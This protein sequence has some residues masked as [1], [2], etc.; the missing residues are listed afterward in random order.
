MLTLAVDTTAEFGSISLGNSEVL[1]HEPKGFSGVLFEQIE[2][3]LEREGA[4]LGDIELLAGA[5]GPGSF[6]GVRI[7]LAAIKGLAEVLGKPAIAISNLEALAQF[8]TADLRATILDAKRGEIY[9]ALFDGRGGRVMEETVIA[10]PK[11]L[12]LLDGRE[13]EWISTGF[14]PFRQAAGNMPV[15]TAPRALA[16]TIAQ[17]AIRK[18][19]AG[20]I[21]DPAAIEANYV[22]RSDAEIFWKG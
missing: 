10:F 11:F 18:F 2:K 1:L 20:A 7:G 21:C 14:E 5:S 22:R 6:T 3:L 8:G 9:G 15:V 17:L 19:R 12:E 4:A 16:G 13:F